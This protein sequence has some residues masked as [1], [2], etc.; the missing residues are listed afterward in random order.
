MVSEMILSTRRERFLLVISV[1]LLIASGF[2]A[3]DGKYFL[4]LVLVSSGLIT[5]NMMLRSVNS[6][7]IT[8]ISFFEALRND[9]TT[10]R[11]PENQGNKTM[12][13]LYS[14]MNKLKEHYQEIRMKNEYNETY[15]RTLLRNSSA[16]LL[17]INNSKQIEFINVA[18]S[19][20]A[21]LPPESSNPDLLRIKH[22]SFFKAVC[23]IK[24]GE[25]I[26]YRNIIGGNLQILSF[27]AINIRRHDASLK[28]ISV[29]DIRNELEARELE[30]YRKLMNVMT[31]E[32]MNLLTPLTTVAREL[33]TMFDRFEGDS[34][35]VSIDFETIRTVKSGLQLVDEHGEGLMNFVRNYR[36]ISKVPQPQFENFDSSGWMEQ[37]KIAFA[38]K[39][40]E[41]DIT[42]TVTDDKAV[43]MITADKKLLNQVLINIINNSI[44]GVLQIDEKRRI[45]VRLTRSTGDRVQIKICNNGPAIP[46][47]IQ[48]KI[49]VP[50]FT[51]K[52]NGSGIGLSIS[53]EIVRLHH[54]SLSFVSAEGDQTCFSIEL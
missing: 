26:T 11:F 25:N 8:A 17:V 40:A 3:S 23:D 7:N 4:S 44:D 37:L 24:P 53:L 13:L 5:G 36:K 19:S 20:F 18:A 50:F 1:V 15:Y 54:G 29:N 35:P 51:T 16:G 2:M 34:D 45:D 12:S 33:S 52:T 49:F 46:E 32:I 43:N 30:S 22:P 47:E 38:G 48:D 9:D 41:N 31:H 39:M 21:G 14:G 10:F 42:F 27:K 6:L 28:L